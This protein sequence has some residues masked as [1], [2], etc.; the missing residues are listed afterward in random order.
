PP[1]PPPS[2]PAAGPPGPRNMP[3]PE[4]ALRELA[5]YVG[6]SGQAQLSS[7]LN[8]AQVRKGDGCLAVTLPAS[9]IARGLCT[10]E[11]QDKLCALMRELWSDACPLSLAMAAEAPEP[12]PASPADMA[13]VS[14]L[15]EHPAVQ[16]AAEI[17]EAQLV[18]L[19][20]AA[21]DE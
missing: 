2:A 5:R 20:P 8:R 19:N 12:E 18:A 9:P 7:Y 17:F 21:A 6:K 1:S 15:A 10:A 11:N 16:E 13:A 14:G 3:A 4:Q